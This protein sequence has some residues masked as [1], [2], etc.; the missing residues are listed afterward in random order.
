MYMYAYAYI[1][2][3]V[4]FACAFQSEIRS[5]VAIEFFGF[6]LIEG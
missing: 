2:I 6:N 1:Y 3:Y 4:N 5:R